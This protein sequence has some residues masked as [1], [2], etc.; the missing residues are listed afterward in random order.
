VSRR[1][2]KDIRAGFTLIELLVV[3][4]IIGMLASLLLPAIQTARE[5]ARR[6]LCKNNI[7]QMALALNSYAEAYNEG[8]PAACSRFEIRIGN[9]THIRNLSGNI[10]L[11]D[12]MEQIALKQSYLESAFNYNGDAGYGTPQ[13]RIDPP[14][15][16]IPS[17]MCPSDRTLT[18]PLDGVNGRQQKP[19]LTGAINY[20]WNH[21][22]HQVSKINWLG[23]GP[24]AMSDYNSASK[25][26]SNFGSMNIPDGISKTIVFSETARPSSMNSLGAV[27]GYNVSGANAAN[28][29]ALFNK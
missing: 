1:E 11:L 9:T 24:F 22:D 12:Y 16:R 20:V 4:A 6:M 23:R 25:S 13:G 28:L 17:L 26:Y 27:V 3:I 10:K 18:H 2:Q 21:G 15:V 8:Y 29:Y 7:R 19:Q 14:D 5:A